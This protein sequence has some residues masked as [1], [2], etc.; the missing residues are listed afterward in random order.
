MLIKRQCPSILFSPSFGFYFPWY[1]FYKHRWVNFMLKTII[2]TRR[3]V[4]L[5]FVFSFEQPLFMI[6]KPEVYW[7]LRKPWRD[8]WI[9]KKITKVNRYIELC[10][11]FS[12]I[13]NYFPL[14]RQC[15][16]SDCNSR[17]RIAIRE[18]V[19]S[20]SRERERII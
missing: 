13:I 15:V 19:L 17:E 12:R 11:Q 2:Q 5:I 14:I 9:F 10:S 7:W 4:I 6:S 3:H 16:L 20:K 8:M 1:I 18:N